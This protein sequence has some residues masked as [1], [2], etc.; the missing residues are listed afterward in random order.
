MGQVLPFH[1]RLKYERDRRGWSQDHLAEKVGSDPKTVGRWESGETLPQAQYRRKL[2]ELFGIDA[3]EFGL[4]AKRASSRTR[5]SS[6]A[7]VIASSSQR[8]DDQDRQ[9]RM[10]SED[11]IEAPS[12][13]HF[14]GRSLELNEL[15][16][17]INEDLCRIVTILGVGGV[18]KT[19]FATKLV[20]QAKDAFV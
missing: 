20:E 14:L 17:W 16:R 6:E 19:A 15:K 10:R 11:L 1:E 2:I 8:D 12:L 7:A 13:E 9:H 3:S 18:G 5:S 4:T